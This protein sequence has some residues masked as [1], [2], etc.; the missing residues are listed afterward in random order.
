MHIIGRVFG[1]LFTLAAIAAAV[2]GAFM[3]SHRLDHRPRTDDAFIDADV[4]HMAPDVSGRVVALNLRNNQAV[5]AGDVLFTIDPEPYRLERDEARAQLAGLQAQLS[6]T[7]DQVASQNSKADAASSG[8]VSAQAQLSLASSTLAR[9]EPLLP[10]GFVTA[11]QVDQAR[12]TQ[13]TA[14]VALVQARQQAQEARQGVSSTKPTEQQIEAA[15][16]RLA[17]AERNVRLTNVRAPCDGLITGLNTVAGEYGSAGHPLFTIIDTEQWYAVGNFRE[18][19]LAGLLPGQHARIYVMSAPQQPVDGV[20]DSLAPGVSP[21]EGVAIGGLPRVPRSLSWVRIAQRF[22][23]A[24]PGA[25]APARSDAPGRIRRHRD[26]PLSAQAAPPLV[27]DGRLPGGL[28]ALFQELRPRPERLTDTLRLAAL[29]LAAVT[30]SEVFR[31]PEP[32]VSAYVVLFVSRSERSSTVKTALVAGLAVILAVFATIAVFMI[33]LSE[34]ALRVP[35]IALVTFAAMFFSRISPLGPAAFAAGFIIAYGLTLGDQVLGL[36]LQS[37]EISN[38]T[39]PGLPELLSIPPEEALLHFLL[40]LA[41]VVAMPVGLVVIANLATGAR[42][43]RLLRSALAARL[44]ACAEFCAGQPGAAQALTRSAQEGSTGLAKL[45]ALSGPGPQQIEGS[46]L[47]R[48]TE[49]LA[50]ALLAWPRIAPPGAMVHALGP[51]AAPISMLEQSVRAGAHPALPPVPA[52][53]STSP[54]ERPLAAEIA[55]AAQA[56]ADTLTAP[57][58]PAPAAQAEKGKLISTAAARAIRTPSASP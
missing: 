39:Q 36:S 2:I 4:V 30:I 49:N 53:T 20:V 43:M 8:V 14:Q 11:E 33:S 3:V 45:L 37:T 51:C 48:E 21:D 41:V 55:R 15:Q 56:I 54:G 16:A 38:T 25:L 24:H 27:D 1:A 6:V 13:R 7:A 17:M 31:L 28:T 50:L 19:D 47:I 52:P 12:T 32:A 34:P 9:L 42:P 5:H 35:L 29:V 22:P 10:R 23:R 40:W 46:S 18:T 58:A 44:R 57:P 26:R